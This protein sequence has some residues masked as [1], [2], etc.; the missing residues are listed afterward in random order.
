MPS[1]PNSIA[2]ECFIFDALPFAKSTLVM[3]TQREEEFSPVKNESGNNSLITA[4]RDLSRMYA[5]WLEAAGAQVT[6][7]DA[8][9]CGPIEISPLYA[10]DAEELKEKLETPVNVTAGFYLGE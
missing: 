8:V 10:L 3:E 5:R 9:D 1:Q 2:F 7:K 4:Q 6:C